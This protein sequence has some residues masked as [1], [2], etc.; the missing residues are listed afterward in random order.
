MELTINGTT[1]QVEAEP[2]TPLLWVIRDNLG[3]TGTKYGLFALRRILRSLEIDEEND[4]M[5]VAGEKGQ[6]AVEDYLFARYSMYA[7]VYYHRKNLAARS[8]LSKLMKRVK[9]L[10]SERTRPVCFV[11]E[12]TAKWFCGDELT[13]DEYLELDDV[14]LT[15]HIKRW[16]SDPDPILNDLASRF[17]HRRL[18]KAFKLPSADPTLLADVEKRAKELVAGCSLDPDYYIGI[19][20]TGFRPYDYY[21]PSDDHPQTNIIIRTDNGNYTELSKIS[22]TVDALVKGNYETHWLVYPEE[23]SEKIEVIKELVPAQ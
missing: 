7:Q 6:V 5:I 19:E 15:Y 2:D 22:L 23:I 11:D 17:L 3:M 18:F 13:V 14:E 4:R 12:H 21:R 20:T 8:L 16:V 1:H 10:L 9:H